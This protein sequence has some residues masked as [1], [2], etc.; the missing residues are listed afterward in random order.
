MPGGRFVSTTMTSPPSLIIMAS[1]KQNVR[2]WLRMARSALAAMS[3]F[4]FRGTSPDTSG[5][6]SSHH[7][8]VAEL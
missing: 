8:P 7:M 2:N 5:M 4:G 6:F 3:L 1:A